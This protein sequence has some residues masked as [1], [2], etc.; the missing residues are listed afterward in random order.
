MEKLPFLFWKAA[1]AHQERATVETGCMETCSTTAGPAFIP[2]ECSFGCLHISFNSI[3]KNWLQAASLLSLWGVKYSQSWKDIP[4]HEENI[5]RPRNN[6]SQSIF[7]LQPSP[8]ISCSFTVINV[9]CSSH[10]V[11]LSQ[12]WKQIFSLTVHIMKSSP[13]TAFSKLKF[14]S[15]VTGYPRWFI[16]ALRHQRKTS[17]RGHNTPEGL[18]CVNSFEMIGSYTRT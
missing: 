1:C 13:T 2:R 10:H 8:F 5:P 12:K 15:W 18:F 17:L 3:F 4:G 14:P 6:V 9:R 7:C 16:L 11:Q